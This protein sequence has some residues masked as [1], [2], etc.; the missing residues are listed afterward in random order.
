MS[1]IIT[2]EIGSEHRVY[3]ADDLPLSVGGDA[4]HPLSYVYRRIRSVYDGIAFFSRTP[5]FN[6]VTL[7]NR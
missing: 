1:I 2:V 5:S 7:I 4:C 3:T 6:D